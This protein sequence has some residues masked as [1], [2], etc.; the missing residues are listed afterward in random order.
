MDVPHDPL[1]VPGGPIIYDALRAQTRKAWLS[2][3]AV[4]ANGL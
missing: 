4:V 3:S 1:L 2:V